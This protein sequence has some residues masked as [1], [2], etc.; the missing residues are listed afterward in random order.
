MYAQPNSYVKSEM[1]PPTSRPTGSVG[2]QGDSKPANGVPAQPTEAAP[3]TSNEEEGEQDGQEAEY[4]HGR[5]HYNYSNTAVGSLP[6]DQHLAPE[7]TNSP[8]HQAGSG[9]ATPRTTATAQGY[10]PQTGGYTPPNVQHSSS[11]L[12]SVISDDRTTNGT[13]ASNSYAQ[14]GDIQNGYS[15]HQSVM[16]GASTGVKRGRDDDE[17]TGMDLKRRKTLSMGDGMHSQYP[18]MATAPPVGGTPR[19]R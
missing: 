7:L 13:A 4:T 14:Q 3:H 11:N 15:S 19:R 10:Y 17:D 6:N 5:P 2:E 18:S 1:G 16:N 12:Y 9:R 8:G